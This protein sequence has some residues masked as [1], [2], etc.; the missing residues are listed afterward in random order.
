MTSGQEFLDLGFG[1]IRQE[2]LD[3]GISTMLLTFSIEEEDKKKKKKKMFLPKK[4][5]APTNWTKN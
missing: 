5:T 4:K 1:P 3:Q 2:F